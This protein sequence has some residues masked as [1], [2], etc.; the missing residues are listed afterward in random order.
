M[1]A[2]GASLWALATLALLH[3]AYMATLAL[4]LLVLR[5]GCAFGGHLWPDLGPLSA[6]EPVRCLS[7]GKSRV[8]APDVACV[9]KHDWHDHQ[10]ESPSGACASLAC[11]CR[12]FRPETGP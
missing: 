7:C 5:V 2:E 6:P 12:S 8:A 10:A 1:S 9:C 4:R 11:G 3:A